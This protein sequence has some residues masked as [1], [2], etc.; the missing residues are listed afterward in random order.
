M[1][2]TTKN[3]SVEVRKLIRIL[4]KECDTGGKLIAEGKML[5]EALIKLN[6]RQVEEIQVRMDIL[7]RHQ[8]I[9]EAERLQI[10]RNVAIL[11]GIMNERDTAIPP[12]S[13]LMNRVSPPEAKRLGA[14][15]EDILKTNTELRA[16]NERNRALLQNA[17]EYVRYTMQY[18][19]NAAL[20]P[21]KYGINPNA[22]IKPVFFLDQRC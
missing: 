17:I 20:Q 2:E 12:L 10:A 9:L 6:H 18:L 8:E 22:L 3:L 16:M 5:T 19:S 4:Q 15:R 14:I 7:H 11:S 13:R 21:A 1:A